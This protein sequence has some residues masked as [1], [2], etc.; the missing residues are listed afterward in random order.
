[1]ALAAWQRGGVALRRGWQVATAARQ[2]G[3]GGG[4]LAVAAVAAGGCG[5]LAQSRCAAV[6]G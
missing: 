5:S 1:M 2:Y 6:K 4:S 3:G